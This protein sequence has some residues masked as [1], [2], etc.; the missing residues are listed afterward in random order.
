MKL[1]PM[2]DYEDLIFQAKCQ[3]DNVS[4]YFDEGAS[5]HHCEGNTL[6]M[7]LDDGSEA[8]IDLDPIIDFVAAMKELR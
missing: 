2:I 8:R 7:I 5:L 3:L 1:T 6:F 4:D